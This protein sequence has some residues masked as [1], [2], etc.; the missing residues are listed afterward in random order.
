[1]DARVF[2]AV[3][4]CVLPVFC[5]PCFADN[6]TCSSCADCSAKLNGEYDVVK[7]TA[8]L[9]G[10]SGNCIQFGSGYAEFDCQGHL[11]AGDEYAGAGINIAD[12]FSLWNAVVRNC[13]VRDF[14]YGIRLLNAHQCTLYNNTVSSNNDTGIR[15]ENSFYNSLYNN[16]I[17][18]N[19]F[20]LIISGSSHPNYVREN[21][22]SSNTWIGIY[23]ANAD[24]TAMNSNEACYNAESDIWLY[25]SDGLSGGNNTCGVPHAW[26]DTG[27]TG[28]AFA[29]SQQTSTTTTSSTSPTTSTTL[30]GGCGLPGDEPPCGTVTLSEV[31]SYINLWSLGAADLGDIVALINAWSL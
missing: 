26:N 29:C 17:T 3:F 5:G 11:I 10:E 21:V 4:F 30:P 19:E 22:V 31:V 6:A 16:T 7:L 25:G 15:I 24:Y 14:W 9:T 28:C 8:D 2:C 18:L 1:M 23:L 20:G 27:T 13:V 12:S